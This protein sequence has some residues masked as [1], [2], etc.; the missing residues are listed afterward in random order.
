MCGSLGVDESNTK[1]D[2]VS[3]INDNANITFS[4]PETA[5]ALA[6]DYFHYYSNVA[7]TKLLLVLHSHHRN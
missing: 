5:L 6:E 1:L 2:L 7:T 4:T 3:E